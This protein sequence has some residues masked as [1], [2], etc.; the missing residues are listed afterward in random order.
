MPSRIIDSETILE[1][2]AILGE[3]AN[4]TCKIDADP[5]PHFAWMGP[6]HQRM[7]S[8]DHVKIKQDINGSQ[9]VSV[10]QVLMTNDSAFGNYTCKAGN[11]MGSV[12]I[13][14]NLKKTEKP[15]T[16]FLELDTVSPKDAR[17]RVQRYKPL[18][19]EESHAQSPVV[20]QAR[21]LPIIDYIVE[22]KL[23]HDSNWYP[24][25]FSTYEQGK[26]IYKLLDSPCQFK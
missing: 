22:S 21:D 7:N 16:P 15:S 19:G 23:A 10:L 12:E 13:R 11:D 17:I 4:L 25:K 5:I 24:A 6:S 26:Q 8:S 2:W 18:P 14:Y 1:S 20:V 3:W 9:Y